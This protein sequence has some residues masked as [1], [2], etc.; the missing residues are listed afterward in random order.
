MHTIVFAEF[1]FAISIKNDCL[2]STISCGTVLLRIGLLDIVFL[3]KKS[4][5]KQAN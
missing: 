3:Y 2:F 5:N 1:S 4:E